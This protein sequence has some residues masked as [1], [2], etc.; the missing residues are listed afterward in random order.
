MK[1][2]WYPE[3]IAWRWKKET[4]EKHV[5]LGGEL[6][7]SSLRDKKQQAK[8]IIAKLRNDIEEYVANEDISLGTEDMLGSLA[9]NLQNI[10]GTAQSFLND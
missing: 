6:E 3:Q 10:E 4:W 1:I 8:E 7:E 5:D 2:Y 9:N